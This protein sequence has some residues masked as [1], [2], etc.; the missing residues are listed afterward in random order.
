MSWNVTM[1]TS[2]DVAVFAALPSLEHLDLEWAP[3]TDLSPLASSPKLESLV[4]DG[5]RLSD[6]ASL[7][8][9]GSLRAL[10]VR[11]LPKKA[12]RSL[13]KLASLVD[14]SLEHA[15]LGDYSPLGKLA[16]LE[17]LKRVRL[18]GAETGDCHRKNPT[19]EGSVSTLRKARPNLEVDVLY[20]GQPSQFKN[21][22]WKW[23]A[24]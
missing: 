23:F 6:L 7:E 14:L 11:E 15:K 3:V 1:P 4:L 10:S 13:E 20:A 18:G 9:I 2:I 22:F 17:S 21:E 19:F 12:G 24:D 8:K 16:K 5:S